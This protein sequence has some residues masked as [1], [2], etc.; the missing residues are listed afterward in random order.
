MAGGLVAV[1]GEPG[2]GKTT[3][4]ERFVQE[5]A[6]TCRIGS[7][8]CSERLAGAE[9]HLPIL[10]ALDE[11]TADPAVRDALRRKGPTWARYLA[12]DPDGRA[13]GIDPSETGAA[14][15]PARL[16][17]ELTIFLED[18]S[19]QAPLV[20]F[21]D[22][23]HWADLSTIDVLAHLAPRLGRMRLLLVVTYRQHENAADQASLRSAA[24]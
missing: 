15:N 12:L 16:M 8:R 23:L 6:G 3:I 2:I 1:T 9:S 11:L 10:E 18:T 4:V 13:P 21:I 14:T 19:R 5:V 17:R 20:I 22:D 7:G 24:R